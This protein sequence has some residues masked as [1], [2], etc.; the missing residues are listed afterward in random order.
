[1][2]LDDALRRG[3]VSYAKLRAITRVATPANEGA[4]LEIAR[5]STGHQLETV[6]RKYRSV[7]RH[8]ADP[9]PEA[10]RQR[11]WIA[12]RDT[13]DGMVRI[14]A[15][16]HPEEAALVWAALDHRAQQ[17]CRESHRV[18]AETVS[19][20]TSSAAPTA[21]PTRAPFDRADALVQ[22]A[23]GYLRGDRPDRSPIELVVSV[24]AETLRRRRAATEVPDP[25]DVA[26][27]ADGTCVSAETARRLS[28]DCGV[29]EIVSDEHGAPLSVGRKRRTIP[30]SMKRA[31]L[32]RDRTCRFPGCGNRLYLEAHHIVHW[33]DGGDTSLQNMA[34]CCSFHHRF[35]H[36]CAS[37]KR[38]RIPMT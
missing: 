7:L 1:P 32:Q 15:V 29:V 34:A 20:E 23:Q 35:V 12:R 28:C 13:A 8:D 37:R 10:D 14:E 19:A 26:C 25:C 3:E 18:S 11:R 4:L 36:E 31:L 16:L 17:Q 30:G 33:A 24:P 38:R 27:L 5:L 2:L 9:D 22:I 21:A 6:C